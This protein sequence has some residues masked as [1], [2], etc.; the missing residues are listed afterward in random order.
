MASQP[1][2][3]RRPR[4]T[5]PANQPLGP[6]GQPDWTQ[7]AGPFGPEPI[8]PPVPG[9]LGNRP[10]LALARAKRCEQAIRM[11]LAGLTYKE[12]ADTL[13]YSNSKAAHRAVWAYIERQAPKENVQQ[14]RMLEG[15][16]YDQMTALLW[17]KVTK[18]SPPGELLPILDRVLRLSQA[19][20]QLW[21]L[22]LQ[23]QLVIAPNGNGD[24]EFNPERI[25]WREGFNRLPVE[26]RQDLYR[27]LLAVPVE[28]VE[29]R[30]G[31]GSTGPA[32]GDS[33]E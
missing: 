28:A 6:D 21:G 14:M 9:S 7:V 1:P 18:D 22:D 2:R 20:R 17:S 13:G 10:D 27:R 16:R 11:H 31:N 12:I 25:A 4:G 29:I 19:R 8:E 30:P 23:P 24:A 32:E 15:R 3:K 26:E 33:E 5:I